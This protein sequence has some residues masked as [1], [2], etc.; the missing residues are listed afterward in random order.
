MVFKPGLLVRPLPAAG[1][2]RAAGLATP[3]AGAAVG[4]ESSLLGA[5]AGTAAA[6]APPSDT[7]HRSPS[8]HAL[9]QLFCFSPP[10][11]LDA[12]PGC[13]VFAATPSLGAVR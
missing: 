5:K 1:P 12:G 10:H 2:T 13:Q 6:T 4:G 7:A 8:E 11:S 3:V 9:K